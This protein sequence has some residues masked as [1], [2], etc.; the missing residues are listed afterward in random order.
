MTSG[1]ANEI[2]FLLPIASFPDDLAAVYDFDIHGHQNVEEFFKK[3]AIAKLDHK[4]GAGKGEAVFEKIQLNSKKF[5]APVMNGT[6]K[7]TATPAGVDGKLTGVF[8]QL[9]GVSTP[10][11]AE[12]LDDKADMACTDLIQLFWK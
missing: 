10:K 12:M 8:K 7:V 11:A 3:N 4:L 1:F 6:G 9:L 2:E 5:F